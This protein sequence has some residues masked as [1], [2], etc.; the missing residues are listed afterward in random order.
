VPTVA[1]Q[2]GGPGLFPP[3]T[4]KLN[5]AGADISGFSDNKSVFM[6]V[7]TGTDVARPDGAPQT[8]TSETQIFLSLYDYTTGTS[9]SACVALDQPSDFSIDSRLRG[10]ALNTTLSASPSCFGSGLN[11]PITLSASWTGAGPIGSSTGVSNY[12]CSGYRA[13]SNGRE[14][15]NTAIGQL[16]LTIDGV[17]TSFSSNLTGLNSVSS[18]LAAQGP[19]DPGCG[20]IGFGSGPTPAGRFR[21]YGLFANGYFGLPPGPTSQVSLFDNN[22]SSQP[23]GGPTTTASEIDLDVAFLGGPFNG[24]GCFAIPQSDV[25]FNGLA[26]AS[27]HTTVSGSP[28]CSN[29][30]PGFGLSFPLNVSATWTATGPLMTMHEQSN[31]QCQ[32]Y[33]QSQVTFI[34]NESAAS[35]A[36]V[37]MPD[38]N[39]NPVTLSLSDGFGSLTQVKQS[40]QA[41]GVWPQA[42]LTRG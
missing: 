12:A 2:K 30:Y 39:N 42:C 38:Y 1:A 14:L 18:E 15:S 28:I 36:T 20:I 27:V 23:T 26:S 11:D 24:Y 33:T 16:T 31:Y 3:G 13:E 8:K 10:A 35:T 9:T 5:F 7:S 40:V 29:S 19:I 34:Q 4:Y 41:N 32:G 25:T 17:S 21:S 6:D 22:Q 37:T